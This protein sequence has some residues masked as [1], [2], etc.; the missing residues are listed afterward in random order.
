MSRRDIEDVLTS[1]RR[2]VSHDAKQPSPSTPP[3]RPGPSSGKLV[4]TSALRVDD[5]APHLQGSSAAEPPEAQLP[6]NTADA[7]HADHAGDA[8]SGESAAG[9]SAAPDPTTGEQD[10]S[11]ALP[12]NWSG[13]FDDPLREAEPS[14]FT[15]LGTSVDGAQPRPDRPASDRSP[16]GVPPSLPPV[17]AAPLPNAESLLARIQNRGGHA[18]PPFAEPVQQAALQPLAQTRS[19]DGAPPL[20]AFRKARS[21]IE[22][23]H[24]FEHSGESATGQGSHKP[25]Q[26]AQPDDNAASA[27]EAQ[28][29]IEDASLEATLT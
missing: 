10:E 27:Q 11:D 6:D 23:Q 9:V 3:E 20:V 16:L 13:L 29:S 19:E 8:K 21:G 25:L 7:V 1:I 26:S 2:L 22:P 17:A 12:D 4:L 18:A 14:L 15:D 5:G 28:Q 24:E